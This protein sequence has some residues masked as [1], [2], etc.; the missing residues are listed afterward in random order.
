MEETKTD[1]GLCYKIIREGHGDVPK[2]GDIVVAHYTGQLQ[3][4]FKFD[5]SYDRRVPFKFPLGKG[6]VIKGW[7]EAF[8]TMKI[9]EQ[10]LLQIPPELGYGARGMGQ[11]P[12]NAILIFKVE[13]VGIDPP[14]ID[15]RTKWSE[16]VVITDQKS[17]IVADT[18]FDQEMAKE[19]VKQVIDADFEDAKEIK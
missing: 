13:L 11:I 8:S 2:S 17:E 14:P 10:R 16:P 19:S 1:S 5:S 18:Q 3:N 15:G 4:G 7:D 6:A 12:P 9:G